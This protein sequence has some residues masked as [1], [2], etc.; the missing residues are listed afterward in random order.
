MEFC[1]AFKTLV[2]VQVHNK[3]HLGTPHLP[4]GL[5]GD[6]KLQINS[7]VHIIVPI[8]I[9]CVSKSVNLYHEA[10]S[11]EKGNHCNIVYIVRYQHH[12][13]IRLDFIKHQPRLSSSSSCTTQESIMRGMLAH[14][15]RCYEQK[16][17]CCNGGRTNVGRMLS[18]YF[19]QIGRNFDYQ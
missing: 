12:L 18:L 16:Q 6:T 19:V 4:L 1:V 3:S 8:I 11:D 9:Q 7:N 2:L 13:Q 5:S 17:L 15:Y 10:I 14:I